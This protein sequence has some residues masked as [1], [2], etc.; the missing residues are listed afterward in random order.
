MIKQ[1]LAQ[2]AKLQED[3]GSDASGAESVSE[4]EEP[5]S[6]D[7]DA[8]GIVKLIYT[9]ASCLSLFASCCIVLHCLYTLMS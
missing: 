1:L 6:D 7:A 2:A 3:E 8:H 9:C 4:T 5:G